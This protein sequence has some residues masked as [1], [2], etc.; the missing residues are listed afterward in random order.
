M[1]CLLDTDTTIL[2]MRGLSIKLPRSDKQRLRHETGKRVLNACRL[3]AADG[4]VIGL[5]AITI[6]ELEFGACNA[7]EPGAE[8]ARMKQILAPFVKFDFA[9]DGPAQ[10]YGE[11]RATLEAKGLGIGPNDLLIAAHALALSAVLVTNNTK[12]FKRVRGLRC[13]NWTF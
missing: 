8:R 3:H 13:E 10:R 12:E 2:M 9:A 6:A 1:I 5:S 7:D 11:V 4:D